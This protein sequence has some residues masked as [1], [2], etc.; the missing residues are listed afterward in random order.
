VLCGTPLLLIT[1]RGLVAPGPQ[2]DALRRVL[3]P[4]YGA[5]PFDRFYRPMVR[6]S[7]SWV[8][9]V[10]AWDYPDA[11]IESALDMLAAPPRPPAS[12]R[13]SIGVPC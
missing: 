2:V 11:V 4:S 3:Q 8:N 9:T 6:F 5:V 10:D 1:Y 13:P 12:H 7:G